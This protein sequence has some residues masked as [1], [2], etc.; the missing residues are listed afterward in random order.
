MTLSGVQK[1]RSAI[2]R[3]LVREPR[4]LV[5]DDALSSVDAATEAAILE[6]LRGFMAGRTSV[7]ATHRIS[8]VRAADLILVLDHGQVIERGSHVELQ[9]QNGLYARLDRHQRLAD[10]L[11]DAGDGRRARL[12]G[13][14]VIH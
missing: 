9:H 1:Q 14:R 12:N 7:V 8:A 11:V 5:L 13:Q 3:A 4:L 10:A 6:G 2:A